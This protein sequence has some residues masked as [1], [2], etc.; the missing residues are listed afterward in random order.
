[1]DAHFQTFFTLLLYFPPVSHHFSC[2]LSYSILH[3]NTSAIFSHFLS[4][5]FSHIFSGLF[6][7]NTQQKLPLKLIFFSSSISSDLFSLPCGEIMTFL[8]LCFLFISNPKTIFKARLNYTFHSFL[9][10]CFKVFLFFHFILTFSTS[11]FPKPLIENFYCSFVFLLETFF[12]RKFFLPCLS[13]GEQCRIAHFCFSFVCLKQFTWKYIASLSKECCTFSLLRDF[14]VSF[15]FPF[16]RK[17][18]KK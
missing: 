16:I 7:I 8:Y 5:F 17:E 1:M 11:Y 2:S 18:Q 13:H 6:I 9:V 15:M 10:F 12:F 14:T 3:L 4:L